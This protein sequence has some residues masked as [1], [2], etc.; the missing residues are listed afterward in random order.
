MKLLEDKLFPK[1][2][3]ERIVQNWRNY[4]N[5]FDEENRKHQEAQMQA[6]AMAERE[7][8]L[9][10]IARKEANERRQKASINRKRQLEKKNKKR[11]RARR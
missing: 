3:E 2:H 7:D 10:Q 6:R 8:A 5:W 4:Q 11:S 1:E 9:R